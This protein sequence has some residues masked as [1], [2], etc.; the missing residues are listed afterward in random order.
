MATFT[1]TTTQNID[2]LASKVG[3]D[4][5]NINGGTLIIDQDSRYGVNQNTSASLGAL[6]IS[7]TLG[8]VVNIDARYVRLIPF[9]TGTGTVPASGT[10]ITKGGASGTMIGVW[11][12]ITAAPTAAGA[13]MPAT[14]FIKI[15]AWNSVAY[16]AGALTGISASATGV[17]TTGWIDLVGDEAATQTLNRLGTYNVLGAWYELGTTTGVANQTFQVPT[18]GLTKYIA[19]VF[20]EKSVGSGDFE[21]YASAGSQTTVATDIRAKVVWCTTAGVVRLGHNGT[22]NAGYTPVSGLRVVIGNIFMENC[23]TAA[24]TANALPNATLATRY[25][26]TTTGAGV[27]NI[28]KCNMAWYLSAA[29]A[30]SVNL[31]NMGTLEAINVSEIATAMTWTK[32]GVGQ[33]AAQTN[34]ALTMAL[35]FA[36]GTFTDCHFTRA[37]LANGN[38]TVSLTDISGF[39][40]INET[41]TAL[42]L[43]TNATSGNYTLTRVN[44]CTYTS[45]KTI[46]GRFLL[47]T[48]ANLTFTGTS[49]VDVITATTNTTAVQNSYVW[50]IGTVCSDILFD[51]LDFEGIANVNPYL[52]VL[53]ILAAGCIRIK[54]RNI[55]T[56]ASPLALGTVNTSAY[57][58]SIATGA[59]ASDIKVQRCYVSNT[60]TNLFTA[61]NSSTKITFENV[62]GDY[63]DVPTFPVLNGKF[64][65]IGMT[66][67]YAAQTA[68]YGTHF[69]DHFTS[70]TVGRIALM[71]NEETSLQ[72]IY[73]INSGTPAFTSAGGLYMPTIGQ[74]ITFTTPDWIIGHSSF[75][76]LAPVMAGGTIGNYTL[77]Y[78]ID[79]NDGAGFGIVKTMSAANLSTETGINAVLGFKMKWII[80]TSV[81][82][83]TAITSLYIT[84]VSSTTTQAYQYPL[85]TYNLNLTGLIIGSD[86]VFYDT[87]TTTVLYSIDA[88]STSTATYNYSATDVIDIGVFCAGYI[89]LYIRGLSIGLADSTLPI[90]QVVDRAYLV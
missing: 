44:N 73:T 34:T 85:E 64:K 43:K 53:S 40:F 42:S 5:Y 7:A 8:G 22:A 76:N 66:P 12:A 71:M 46:N 62:F 29:Q 63:A 1:I 41:C 38:Y 21:F 81:T 31:S 10:T 87:G 52:G 78:Q 45:P 18:S 80:T 28:D 84:T 32:V 65:G 17:D 69:I 59:A 16:S 57:L 61:D 39:S 56:Y 26:Y 77:E 88:N 79:K 24:R 11:S 20:I 70:A 3:G 89:P 68:I 86:I 60:R 55:G 74:K 49:Y 37:T 47:T 19:G 90:A 54:L 67:T 6:T 13:A 35:C 23:T 72:D 2:A 4:I 50:E 33:T 48:C 14:G 30:Y 51:G 9:N 82:N 36:G 83:A 15:K 25:D 75:A 58:I 27:I